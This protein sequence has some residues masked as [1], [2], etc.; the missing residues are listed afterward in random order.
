QLRLDARGR[1]HVPLRLRGRV[2]SEGTV[3][4]EA[5]LGAER[6]I[7]ERSLHIGAPATSQPL[8][9]RAFLGPEAQEVHL[10]LP[11]LAEATSLRLEVGAP[12]AALA[13]EALERLSEPRWNLPLLRLDRL[14]SLAALRDAAQTLPASDSERAALLRRLERAAESE[15]IAFAELVRAGGEV[16]LWRGL[17]GDA[18]LAARAAIVHRRLGRGD[19]PFLRAIRRALRAGA[20]AG[21]ALPDAS[22][23]PAH[24]AALLA[25]ALAGSAARRD[26]QL[27]RELL[28]LGPPPRGLAAWQAALEAAR[29]LDDAAEIARLVE[30]LGDALQASLGSPRL[31]QSCAGP[32]PFLCLGRDGTRGQLAR[33]AL[34]LLAEGDAHR[35]LAVRAALELARRPAIESRWIWGSA[36][37]DEIALMAHLRAGAEAPRSASTLSAFADGVRVPIRGG[38][39]AISPGVERLVLRIAASRGR[40]SQLGVRGTLPIAPPEAPRGD[41]EV[42]RRLLRRDEGWR[43]QLEGRLPPR[44]ES[45]ELSVPLPAGLTLAPSAEPPAGI[46]MLLDE[47]GLLLRIERPLE[48]ASPGR[49]RRRTTRFQIELPL[50]PLA[51]GRFSAGPPTLRAG[52]SWAIGMAT[53]IE[54]EA[55]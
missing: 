4:V 25:R 35:A 8:A 5:R 2:A 10:A 42:R 38:E 16:P 30:G 33:A 43:L 53:Q 7:S 20:E 23:L 14:E 36:A 19:E 28:R 34:A 9:I 54:I 40:F 3:R 13:I 44:T 6:A 49:L 26:Q 29:S 24:E 39:I 52:A 46:S 15:A 12:I 48:H 51:P 22:A 41:L 1:A 18:S 47:E 27:A 37:A 17:E 45:A 31:T 32:A 50:L 55:R 21:A 11:E